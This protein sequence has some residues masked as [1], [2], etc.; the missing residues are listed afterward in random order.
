VV[1]EAHKTYSGA[2]RC[3][4]VRYQAIGLSDI[5][6][7]HCT[8]CQKLTGHHIAAAGTAKE[9]LSIQGDIVWSAIS[10]KSESGHCAHCHSYLFWRAHAKPTISVL[11]GSLDDASGLEAKG[12]VYVAEKANY[13]E[14]NDGLPQY[15]GYP[16]GVLR[17]T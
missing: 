16:E 14:I 11:V 1:D 7:C 13:Y 9:N 4:Q 5:W 6:Y 10:D 12:H 17:N 3:G 15:D 2:C 8:Q